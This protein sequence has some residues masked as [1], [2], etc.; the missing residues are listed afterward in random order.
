[1]NILFVNY[2]DFTTN[3]LNHIAGFANVLCRRGH[4]CTVAVPSGRETFAAV[5]DPLFAPATYAE[6]LYRPA[7][8]PDGR[9]ADLIHAWTPREGVRK[10][11]LAYQARAQARLVVHLEDN[12]EHLIETWMGRPFAELQDCLDS[13]IVAALQ[14]GLPHPVRHRNLMRLA[15]GITVIVDGLRRLVPAG[16]P[17][18]TLWPGVDLSFYAPRPPD[19]ALARELGVRPFEKVIVY[20]GSRTFANEPE[21]RELYEAV[22]LLNRRGRPARLLHTGFSSPEFQAGFAAAFR[23]VAVELGFVDKAR[24]PGL[25]AL[26]DVL[27]QPGHP[28]PFNDLRLPSKIPEFL[29]AGRPVVMPAANVGLEVTDGAQACLLRT[30][31]PAEIADACIRIFDDPALAERLGREGRAFAV[32]RFD[33]KANTAALAGFYEAVHAAPPRADWS[34]ACAPPHGDVP[35]LARQLRG[36]IESLAGAFPSEARAPWADAAALAAD[37]ERLCRQMQAD[38]AESPARAALDRLERE[39]SAHGELQR[40]FESV[41]QHAASLELARANLDGQVAQGRYEVAEARARAMALGDHCRDELKRLRDLLRETIRRK[42]DRIYQQDVKIRQMQ[43]TFSWRV[44]APLRFLRR[45]LL[46]PHRRPPPPAPAAPAYDFSEVPEITFDFR[47]ADFLPQAP[48][49]RISVDYPNLWSFPPRQ[50]AIRGWC[51]SMA[52]RVLKDVRA[53]IDGRVYPGLYGLKRMDV[54]ANFREHPQAEYCGYKIDVDLR[55][56]DTDLVLEVEDAAGAWHRFFA[57]RLHV[58]SDTGQRELTDYENW[59]NIYDR[60][61][62]ESLTALAANIPSFASRPVV[63]ILLPVYNTP[64]PWLIRAIESV[65]AQAYPDWQLCVADDASSAPHVRPLLERYAAVDPRIRVVFRGENGHIAAASNSALELA[66][67]EWIALLDHD[68]ELAP[69]ALYEVVA[70]LNARPETDLIYSDEDKI[71]REGR[72]H[73]PYC[74]PDFLPDL[75]TGQNYLSHLVVFRGSILRETGGFR[76]GLEGSQDWDLTLR[77]VERTRPGR[78]RH[79]PKVLYHWRTIAGS[80]A[81]L[82]DEKTYHLEAARRALAEHFARRGETVELLPV[83]GGHWRVRRPVPEPPPLVSLVMPTRNGF[84][85]LRRCVDSILGKTAYPAYELLIVDN[86]SDDPET[87]AYLKSLASGGAPAAGNPPPG[88]TVRILRDDAPFNYS[89]L[90][91]RAV[92]QARGSVIGLLN[93]DLEVINGDWLDEMVSQAVRPEVGCVGAMLYYPND[94]IQHAGVILGVG[95]VAAHAFRD[96]ERGSEGRFNR[97]RLVQNYS[98]VTAACLLVRKSVYTQVG[99]LDEKDLAVAFNDIDF[100]LK[101][102]SAGYVNL[103]TP[104]A[105]LYHHESAS[106]GAD[107]TEEKRERFRHETETMLARW[108]GELAGDPAYNPNLTLELTDFSLAALPRPWEPWRAAGTR[109]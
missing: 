46:D 7:C 64:E 73:S 77:F 36:R 47:A 86:G 29:A 71:D 24:L 54:L 25:L 63:S 82:S 55:Q 23:D 19:P 37:L 56:G 10:F 53:T 70:L 107:D 22:R 106:R 40:A 76:V 96:L 74:K 91:N 93:N 16:V 20:T 72:R 85:V 87:L 41:R 31:S 94:T 68:D 105:E 52:G 89:S 61:T 21:M 14:G 99:G 100:C 102:R 103:W 43:S 92:A 6:L 34:A 33:L 3:S 12:E 4:A 49:F 58:D 42:E 81:L 60:H 108:G 48:E 97:T 98:A 13:E 28:G 51:L 90:N 26:A 38:A 66:T 78:I 59:I 32:A 83:P 75:F 30:G 101:V 80:T 9:P 109:R 104:F 27:V 18:H 1:M 15:D 5:R 35:L 50:L 2:G 84:K 8:F 65:R 62:P 39:R 45:H 88:K 17:A 95:G 67:G 69:H 79:I 57:A 44:T 11:V